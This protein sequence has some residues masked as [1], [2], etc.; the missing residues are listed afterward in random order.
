MHK[1]LKLLMCP[2]YDVVPSPSSHTS[3][4][5][6]QSAP[7]VVNDILQLPMRDLRDSAD[8]RN[9]NP[10]VC[11]TKLGAKSTTS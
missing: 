2:L 11:A 7:P 9:D 5:A 10:I 3:V 4:V 6:S 8:H 1:T